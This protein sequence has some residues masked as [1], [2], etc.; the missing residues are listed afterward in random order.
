M[1]GDA[2]GVAGLAK[3]WT[4]DGEWT[5]PI[6][7][8][9][10]TNPTLT[11]VN[12]WLSE[13]SDIF[14]TAL[15]SAGFKVPVTESKSVNAI[16][17]IVEEYAA[18]LARA[19]NGEDIST[20]SI[21]SLMNDILKWVTLNAGGLEANGADRTN[22]NVTVDVRTKTSSPIFSRKGFGNKFENW[23]DD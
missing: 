22:T 19:A 11:Q 1:Y 10:P 2:T 18:K 17:L 21:Q 14:N 6:S 16:S 20:S 9:S 15:S 8:S 13:I 4:D 3:I 7:G 12:D 23:N 5:D